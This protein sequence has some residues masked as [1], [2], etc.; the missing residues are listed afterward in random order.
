VII[1][2]LAI[3]FLNKSFNDKTWVSRV[4]FV[5]AGFMV[6]DFAIVNVFDTSGFVSKIRNGDE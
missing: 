3:Q 6:Y 2:R 1:E 4:L 5:L